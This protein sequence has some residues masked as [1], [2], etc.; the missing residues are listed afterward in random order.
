MSSEPLERFANNWA[1]LKTELNWLEKV[2]MV[3]IARQR[4]DTKAVDRL[5]QS[6]A[7]KA[8]SHWW[9][10]VV[11][12]EGGIADETSLQPTRS[13]GK[14]YQVQLE[15]R[16]QTTLKLGVGLALPMLRDRLA[17]TPLEKNVLLIGLAPEI[18]RRYGR[19]YRYLQ[20]DPPSLED[21][22]T[23]DLVLRLF[24]RNDAEWRSAR[25]RLM[26]ASPLV[27]HGL[28]TLLASGSQTTLSQFIGLPESVVNYLLE[29]QPTLEHLE[30]LLHL[31]HSMPSLPTLLKTAIAPVEW[32]ALVLP[33]PL[34]KT[35]QGLTETVQG[36]F[37]QE[38]NSL[39]N[40]G[41]M[42]VLAGAAGTG[43]TLAAEAIA[44]A[45][46][47]PLTSVDLA[48]ISPSDYSRLLSD[49]SIEAPPVLLIQS[50]DQWLR[51]STSMD[52]VMLHH[53]WAERRNTSGITLLAVQHAESVSLTWQRQV[54]QVLQ[55]PLPDAGDR[56]CLWQRSIPDTIPQ[57]TRLDWRT[58]ADQLPL[59]GGKIQAIAQ[60][61][62]A[63]YTASGASELQMQH[64]LDALSDQGLSVK[65]PTRKPSRRSPTA[66]R[67][68]Q[69]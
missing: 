3:A 64:L 66:K 18:N 19:L 57:A 27:Q 49:L 62:L 21:L 38:K 26:T 52:S 7:D 54:D 12:L 36:Q 42:V 69:S 22:P 47:R 45:L 63:K 5:V 43:K 28:I 44:H 31:G 41:L 37:S 25:E 48:R 13:A 20:G 14:S 56:L 39:V 32:S 50:V 33:D 34:L 24:C 4:K 59:T 15:E 61:A 53:F 67:K 68:K 29:D 11:S 17:L 40:P 2:L 9:K 51:R 46:D 1:Y 8:T 55:F 6:Q 10:G 60:S 35:L 30:G 65:L 16:I 23:V 58:L